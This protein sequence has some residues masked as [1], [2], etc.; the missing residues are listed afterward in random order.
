MNEMGLAGLGVMGKSL[1][2]NLLRNGYRLSLFNRHLPG[3]EENIAE[4]FIK[5]FHLDAQGFDQVNAFIYSLQKPRKIILMVEAG[6][7]IDDLLQSMGPHI[8]SGGLNVDG[9]KSHFKIT[10]R[11]QKNF[12]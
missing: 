7:P 4:K 2:R 6:A 12:L 8:E 3:K 5:E 9:G 1:A 10:A 11:R